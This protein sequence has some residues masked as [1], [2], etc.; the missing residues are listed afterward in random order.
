MSA[1]P[2]P[3]HA[4]G[5]AGTP[6]LAALVA[7]MHHR[8]SVRAY[9]PQRIPDSVLDDCFDV[10]IVAPTSHNL[11]C[12]QMIEVRDAVR[13]AALMHPCLDQPAATS[14]P[15]LIVAVARP[16]RWRLGR[17]KMLEHIRQAQADPALPVALRGPF[18]RQE[19]A[20][21]AVKA[22]ALACKNFMLVLTAH[23]FDSCPTE[24]FD[25]PRAKRNLGPPH[26]A[27]A[28]MVIAAGRG[29]V[30]GVIAQI[31]FGRDHCIRRA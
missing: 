29:A 6:L 14:A 13:L 16:D 30:G 1:R 7:V 11:E 28:A 27:E 19:Q 9:L 23:G 18:G 2:T 10:A 24:G 8:R 3:W 5:G 12:W 17:A 22:A 4:R 31:R 26:A 21:W 20:L 25:E 15:H